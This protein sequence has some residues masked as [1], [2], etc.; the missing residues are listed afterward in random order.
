MRRSLLL[1]ALVFTFLSG[2]FA[3]RAL[4]QRAASD[5][6]SAAPAA[7]A[8]E[9]A[10]E[11]AVASKLFYAPTGRVLKRGEVYVAVDAFSIGVVRVGVTDRFS[12]GVGRPLWAN[13]TWITPKVQI[14]ENDHAALATGV[15]HLFAPGVGS[16]GVGYSV[17]TLGSRD[18]AVTAGMGWFY[19]KDDD[20]VRV[21]MPVL[22]VGGDRRMTRRTKFITENYVFDGGA[23]L[24]AGARLMRRHVSMEFGGMFVFVDNAAFP[25]LVVNFVF[26]RDAARRQ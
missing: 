4:A 7:V 21:G 15:L 10:T 12:I 2:P 9:T 24:S 25:G 8:S 26:H 11:D 1:P 13:T 16:G 23:M 22:I 20:G 6:Q 18:N 19:G 5:T 3:S 17:A 14:Y